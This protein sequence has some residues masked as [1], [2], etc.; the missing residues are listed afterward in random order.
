MFQL[1]NRRIHKFENIDM[2]Q[3]LMDTH[4]FFYRL[5]IFVGGL[6]CK[7]N[8]FARCYAMVGYVN[9]SE[10]SNKKNR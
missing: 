3:S 6:G 10:D 2:F 1:D 5:S 7:G 9:S 8:E 4:L